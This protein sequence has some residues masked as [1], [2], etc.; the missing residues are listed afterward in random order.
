MNPFGTPPSGLPPSGFPGSF[1]FSGFPGSGPQFGGRAPGFDPSPFRGREEEDNDA[2]LLSRTAGPDRQ[3][4]D[5]AVPIKVLDEDFAVQ[6]GAQAEK[7][8]GDGDVALFDAAVAPWKSPVA[9]TNPLR[10]LA[11]EDHDLT[12]NLLDVLTVNATKSCALRTVFGAVF[13]NRVNIVRRIMLARERES[14]RAAQVR[15]KSCVSTCWS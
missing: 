15:F 7:E 4:L 2:Q 6:R 12:E 5:A 1:N 10:P 9:D 14:L 3:W 11:D 8:L 13:S